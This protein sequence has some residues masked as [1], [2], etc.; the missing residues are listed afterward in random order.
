MASQRSWGREM[1]RRGCDEGSRGGDENIPVLTVRRE[2]GF[3]T[4]AEAQLALPSN[5]D[6]PD[7]IFL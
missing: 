7:I 6:F 2:M 1:R 4:E 5:S 3:F